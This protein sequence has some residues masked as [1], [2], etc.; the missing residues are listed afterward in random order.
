MHKILNCVLEHYEHPYI[1]LASIPKTSLMVGMCAS[2]AGKQTPN[3]LLKIHFEVVKSTMHTNVGLNIK[4]PI[5]RDLAYN[6]SQ[7]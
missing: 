6:S 2:E 1:N 5:W 7:N 3:K 4:I